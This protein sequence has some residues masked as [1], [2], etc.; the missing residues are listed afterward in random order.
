MDGGTWN[1]GDTKVLVTDSTSQQTLDITAADT[2]SFSVGS[3]A[4]SRVN[5]DLLSASGGGMSFYLYRGGE[6]G[7]FKAWVVDPALAGSRAL[8]QGGVAGVS[9]LITNIL[10][11]S[12]HYTLNTDDYGFLTVPRASSGNIYSIVPLGGAATQLSTIYGGQ[13]AGTVFVAPTSAEALPKASLEMPANQPFI[14]NEGFRWHLILRITN[15]GGAD[16]DFGAYRFHWQA[17]E[18]PGGQMDANSYIKFYDES[19]TEAYYPTP[20]LPFGSNGY[21]ETLGPGESRIYDLWVS[22]DTNYGDTYYFDTNLV[23][24]LSNGD[25]PRSPMGGF[26]TRP[27]LQASPRH[28]RERPGRPA[29]LSDLLHGHGPSVL[30]P[31][32]DRPGLALRAAGRAVECR[33]LGSEGRLG[34]QVLPRHHLPELLRRCARL[35]DHSSRQLRA[36]QQRGPRPTPCLPL[37]GS[38]P[39]SSRAASISTRSTSPSQRRNSP[40]DEV[41]VEGGDLHDGRQ[42]PHG[43]IQPP[44]PPSD[45]LVIFHDSDRADGGGSTATP[46]R[47]EAGYSRRGR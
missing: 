15:Q 23:V 3:L 40:L 17:N 20:V 28:H 34:F 18:G 31:R 21:F 6:T 5:D 38:T 29:P 12:E 45:A 9:L 42:R 39:G 46:Y 22:T 10:N 30:L 37:A 43:H 11:A 25:G 16:T 44:P 4:V 8:G 26:R 41:L 13:L 32:S 35:E 47:S 36:Q 14:F 2:A 19:D 24:S 7:G 27:L 1:V 33:P